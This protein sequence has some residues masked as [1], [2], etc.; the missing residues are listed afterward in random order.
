VR[1][2]WVDRSRNSSISSVY[3]SDLCFRS[4]RARPDT[5]L[6]S[7]EGCPMGFGLSLEFIW[8]AGVTRSEEPPPPP[9][10]HRRALGMVLLYGPRRKRFLMRTPAWQLTQPY[11]SSLGLWLH[12]RNVLTQDIENER[13]R[14][15]ERTREIKRERVACVC[16][17]FNYLIRPPNQ[18]QSFPAVHSGCGSS[19]ATRSPKTPSTSW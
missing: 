5:V 15:R 17:D 7:V 3:I 10:G 18:M 12:A 11:R 6:T 14:E 19:R 13:A 4:R 2:V 1:T 9:K 8:G 16:E